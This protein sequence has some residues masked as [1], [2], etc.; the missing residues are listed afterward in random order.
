MSGLQ[1]SPAETPLHVGKAA[2]AEA[3]KQQ[4]ALPTKNEER[5]PERQP[6][7]QA[8]AKPCMYFLRTGTCDYGDKCVPPSIDFSPS[9]FVIERTRIVLSWDLKSYY[10]EP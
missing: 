4:P 3:G 7:A 10:Q 1:I 9:V 5:E 2:Q 8:Q 6:A